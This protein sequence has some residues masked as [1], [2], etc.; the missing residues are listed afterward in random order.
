MHDTAPEPTTGGTPAV[1]LDRDG[2]LIRDID[3][4]VAVEEVDVLPG[5]GPALAALKAAGFALVGVTNQS[6]VARGLIDE[7]GL[8]ALHAAIDVRLLAAGGV[9][10]DM[11]RYCP[12]H[13]EATL[14]AYRVRCRCRKPAPGMLLDAAR[15]AS[16]DRRRSWLIGDRLSDVAAGRAA[17]CTTIL[18]EG[19]GDVARPFVGADAVD[20]EPDHRAADLAAAVAIILAKGAPGP[21]LSRS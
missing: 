14:P 9:E 2:V 21:G 1:F 6:V 17:G 18:V 5:V 16:L 3:L 4:M 12:H 10:L 8:E 19:V 15:A 7:K 11:W 13:P 20:A